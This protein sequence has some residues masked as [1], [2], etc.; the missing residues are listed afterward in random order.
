MEQLEGTNVSIFNTP[1]RTRTWWGCARVGKCT[2][3]GR[4]V[5]T[6]KTQFNHIQILLG[7]FLFCLMFVLSPCRP[8]S[9]VHIK[10]HWTT[11]Q[12][13]S[14]IK[15]SQISPYHTRRGILLISISQT[16]LPQALHNDAPK[17]SRVKIK[18]PRFTVNLTFNCE[19]IIHHCG[20]CSALSDQRP[21]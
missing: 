13:G 2:I 1:L 16:G 14:I 17:N 6:T 7:F 8:S 15:A 18:C 5:Q 10:C 19:L 20:E 12:V 9:V 11:S 3:Y 4:R 21:S